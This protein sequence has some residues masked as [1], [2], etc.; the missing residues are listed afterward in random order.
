MTVLGGLMARLLPPSLPPPASLPPAPSPASPSP[1]PPTCPPPDA[2]GP[3]DRLHHGAHG[4][5]PDHVQGHLVRPVQLP[6]W[7]PASGKSGVL[8]T[9]PGKGRG[10]PCQGGFRGESRGRTGLPTTANKRAMGVPSS[11]GTSPP[12]NSHVLPLEK[13]KEKV[14]QQEVFSPCTVKF[15]LFLNSEA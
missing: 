2:H 11:V 6:G 9:G 3:D 4:L 5:P 12:R 8:G 1:L 15:S 13:F 10:A 7:L 14:F